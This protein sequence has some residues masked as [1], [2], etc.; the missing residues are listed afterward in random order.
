MRSTL[1]FALGKDTHIYFIR[2]G[3]SQ[4]ELGY[5]WERKYRGWYPRYLLRDSA[6]GPIVK[7]DGVV[8]T[9]DEGGR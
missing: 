6:T 4:P 3:C 8:V 2:I 9:L 1:H 7:Y 5:Y